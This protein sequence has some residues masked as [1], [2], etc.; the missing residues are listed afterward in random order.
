MA[1]LRKTTCCGLREYVGL[2]EFDDVKEALLYVKPTW[3]SW[4]G[5]FMLFTCP[6][7]NTMGKRLVRFIEKHGLGSTVESDVKNNPNSGNNLRVIIWAVNNQAYA[8][9]G[10]SGKKMGVGCTVVGNSRAGATYGLTG[11]GWRGTV[12]RVDGE[13]IDVV[14]ASGQSF[15]VLAS[16]FDVI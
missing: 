2:T 5:A 15:R 7:N 4:R 1:E 13:F 6:T 8:R 12:T 9:F 3:F 14:G 11:L 16:H 10:T